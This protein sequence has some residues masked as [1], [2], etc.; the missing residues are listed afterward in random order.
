MS[1]ILWWGARQDI[2]LTSLLG[3]SLPMSGHTWCPAVTLSEP[4]SAQV[5]QSASC[6]EHQEQP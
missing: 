6:W 5:S 1:E 2:N 3:L 4:L